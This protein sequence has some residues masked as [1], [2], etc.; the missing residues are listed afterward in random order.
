[1]VTNGSLLQTASVVSLEVD[2]SVSV[3]ALEPA[4]WADSL[5]ATLSETLSQNGPA[6][7]LQDF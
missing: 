3:K 4:A 6:K 7:L 5:T 2:S 1:M